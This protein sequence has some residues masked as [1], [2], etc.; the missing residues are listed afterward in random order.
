VWFAVPTIGAMGDV[1]W[2]VVVG[3]AVILLTLGFVVRLLRRRSN[4]GRPAAMRA[5]RRAIRQSARDH[6]RRG[7]GSIRG[8]GFGG[9]DSQGYNAGVMSDGGGGVP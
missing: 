9:N 3:A 5:A 8:R 6:R 1:T 2:M 7:R 4:I